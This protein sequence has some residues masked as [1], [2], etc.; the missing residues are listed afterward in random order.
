MLKKLFAIFTE[1]KPAPVATRKDEPADGQVRMTLAALR[2]AV[3]QKRAEDP[4][5]GAKMGGKAVYQRLLA[6]MAMEQGVHAESVLC[7]LGALAGYACQA[8][9]RRL[10]VDGGVQAQTPFQMKT[11]PDG[12]HYFTGEP[13]DQVL[14]DGKYS[15]WRLVAE[16]G[17]QAGCKR[18]PDI[19]EIRKHVA[20]SI[21]TEAF[22]V[23]RLPI[24]HRPYDMPVRYLEA[25]W[26]VV[27]PI[28]QQ[29]CQMPAE[30]PLLFSLAV[31][32]VIDA[33][34]EVIDAET[35]VKIVME[36]AVPMAIVDLDGV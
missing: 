28:A 29:L 11:T 6:A 9:L 31:Q 23:P 5:L 36:S 3:E 15:L 10:A 7:A 35:A 26:P 4:L 32:E 24:A 14:F 20:D 22:G 2:Q 27:Q 1:A 16:I 21:G 12:R 34:G 30:W 19:A 25:Y 8:S 17:R 33:G 18:L 13:L